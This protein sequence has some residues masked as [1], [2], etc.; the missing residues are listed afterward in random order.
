M[1][2]F[3]VG[4]S[5]KTTNINENSKLVKKMLDEN[6]KNIVGYI[7]TG[8][9]NVMME[10]ERQESIIMKFCEEYNVKCKEIFIDKGYS[11]MKL[12]RPGI[13]KIIDSN[14]KTIIIVSSICKITRSY[15]NLIEILKI[16]RASC[17]ERVST[18]V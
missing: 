15:I 5:I 9:D 6:M 8:R 18:R 7:R 1:S 2:E 17:R 3:M 13:R 12:S 10:K 11:G 14:N 4:D 16:G